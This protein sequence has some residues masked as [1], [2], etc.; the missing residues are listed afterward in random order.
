MCCL[1]FCCQKPSQILCNI[2][3][4]NSDLYIYIHI[5]VFIIIFYSP[6]LEIISHWRHTGLMLIR[7]WTSWSVALSLTSP[8]CWQSFETA[9]IETWRW[10]NGTTLVFS[11]MIEMSVVFQVLRPTF[12]P[13]SLDTEAPAPVERKIRA[14]AVTRHILVRRNIGFLRTQRSRAWK[15][16]NYIF[17]DSSSMLKIWHWNLNG[18]SWPPMLRFFAFRSHHWWICML[19]IP[20][21][22]RQQSTPSKSKSQSAF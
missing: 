21:K 7:T 16:R 18:R 3:W 19:H 10:T 5:Y 6:R 17:K 12:Q 14:V 2:L 11:E 8:C 4:N 13:L 22:L 15:G 9:S 1:S 20:L